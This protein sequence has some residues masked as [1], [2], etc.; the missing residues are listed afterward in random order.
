MTRTE[1][2][3]TDALA[4]RAD[5]VAAGSIRP[6][7]APGTVRFRRHLVSRHWSVSIAPLA[8]AATIALMGAVAM[9][10]QH[11][12]PGPALT[13]MPR[14][15]E[16]LAVAATSASS[17]WAVG[18][19]L[20]RRGQPLIMRWNGKAWSRSPIARPTAGAVLYAVAAVSARYAWAVG[21]TGRGSEARPYILRWNG[22]IWRPVRT[23]PMPTP[24]LL[25][26]VSAVSAWNAWAVGATGSHS[27]V[28][29]WNGVRWIRLGRP[30]AGPSPPAARPHR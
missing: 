2:R 29:H 21:S 27:L 10:P 4:A 6:L 9:L 1:E 17:A 26:E 16:L 22:T 5:A 30:S 3:L 20:G 24:A 15:S 12:G 14:N 23:P 18:A 7:P 13:G 11:H 28:L 8:V 25:K 19:I